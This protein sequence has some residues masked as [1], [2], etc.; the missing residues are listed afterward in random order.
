MH[1]EIKL[2]VHAFSS[3][4][5][6]VTIGSQAYGSTNSY[7]QC[8]IALAVVAFLVLQ[9]LIWQSIRRLVPSDAAGKAPPVATQ[10]LIASRG[11]NAAACQCCAPP[12]A[13]VEAHVQ[14]TAAG[15]EDAASQR[16]I[17]DRVPIAQ[18]PQPSEH[19]EEQGADHQLSPSVRR[20][21]LGSSRSVVRLQDPPGAS[22]QH[23]AIPDK[24]VCSHPSICPT[25]DASSPPTQVH[26]GSASHDNDQSQSP[27][28][29]DISAAQSSPLKRALVSCDIPIGTTFVALGVGVGGEDLP[30]PHHDIDLLS[31]VLPK[32]K[33]RALKGPD[34]TWEAIRQEVREIFK[35]AQSSIPV[36]LYFTGHGNDRNAF[37]LHGNEFIDLN[38]L[39]DWIHQ[40]RKDTGKCPPVFL[41][42]DHCREGDDLPPL[43]IEK[44]ERV[45]IV[46]T[47]SPRQRAYE[48]RLDETLPYSEF[49]K[50]ACLTLRELLEHPP[51]SPTFFL[52]RAIYWMSL[53]VRVH[54][55]FTC[56]RVKCPVP[57]LACLCETCYAGGLCEHP[58]HR[59][60]DMR[61]IQTLTGWF[62]T[63][64]CDIEMNGIIP[65]IQSI[66][67][68]IRRVGDSILCNPQY[69]KH[70]TKSLLGS[71]ADPSLPVKPATR[72]RVTA[73]LAPAPAPASAGSDRLRLSVQ[74]T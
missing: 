74:R 11:P 32:D 67:E 57:W 40:A 2:S 42:F 69:R 41:I 37:K 64:K 6:Q 9:C 59:P 72:P 13:H 12:S 35:R 16:Q 68:P 49:L 48:V 43:L 50:A 51:Q 45:N 22:S 27:T 29:T 28:R 65:V 58:A 54:R 18:A 21:A 24:P 56:A 39:L 15:D 44:L 61:P 30:G 62:W 10:N 1:F 3:T 4:T 46:W 5:P 8:F 73:G 7:F 31:K 55:G 23:S 34:A 38:T 33:F 17:K 20:S 53:A 60:H 26:F 19:T 14:E 66:A 25:A 36:V 47:C 52:E 71:S 63:S 70:T